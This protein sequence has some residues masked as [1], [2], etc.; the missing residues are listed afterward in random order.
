MM[1]RLLLKIVGVV[2]VVGSLVMLGMFWGDAH[3]GISPT[4]RAEVE[5]K[6]AESLALVKTLQT[7]N[8]SAEKLDAAMQDATQATEELTDIAREDNRHNSYWH[9]FYAIIVAV[10]LVGVVALYFGFR[11]PR[12]TVAA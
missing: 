3:R 10:I 12:V 2:L 7:Q 11:K 5:H 4:Y 8:A 6:A 1:K 9:T